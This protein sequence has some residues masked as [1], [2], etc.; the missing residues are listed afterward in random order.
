MPSHLLTITSRKTNWATDFEWMTIQPFPLKPNNEYGYIFKIHI[1]FFLTKI[2]NIYIV[3]RYLFNSLHWKNPPSKKAVWQLMCPYFFFILHPN[4]YYAIK[5]FFPLHKHYHLVAK[6][7][8]VKTHFFS[9]KQTFLVYLRFTPFSKKNLIC[10]SV[11]LLFNSLLRLSCENV[12][13]EKWM[14]LLWCVD[15]QTV[16]ASVLTEK[17]IY[18]VLWYSLLQY[19]NL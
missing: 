16:Y 18:K 4:C 2:F 3:S 1:Y 7:I 5:D 10:L 13:N 12:N 15:I 19:R 11:P 9:H 17:R 14:A 8:N 6:K